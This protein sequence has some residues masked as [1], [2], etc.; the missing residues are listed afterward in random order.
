MCLV[1]VSDT[2]LIWRDIN[3]ILRANFHHTKGKAIKFISRNHRRSADK[4]FFFFVVSLQFC[5]RSIMIQTKSLSTCSN[6]VIKFIKNGARRKVFVAKK[7]TRNIDI[8]FLNFT[9]R[10]AYFYILNSQ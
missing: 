2:S 4:S 3:T 1:D 7:N 5:D 8:H 6:T 10:R 9:Q